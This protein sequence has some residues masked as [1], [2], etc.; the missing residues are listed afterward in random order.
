MRAA[1]AL[2]LLGVVLPAAAVDPDRFMPYGEAPFGPYRAEVCDRFLEHE[3]VVFA[4][5][6]LSGK[7]VEQL[8]R[9]CPGILDIGERVAVEPSGM[10]LYEVDIDNDGNVDQ[11]L[12]LQNLFR[13][14]PPESFFK[15]DLGSC[16]L[17]PVFGAGRPNR[18]FTLAGRTYIESQQRCKGPVKIHGG[19]RYLSCALIYAGDGRELQSYRDELCTFID[20]AWRR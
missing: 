15:L 20:S 17:T 11:V 9:R 7:T 14:L 12:Y 1:A 18:L 19:M 3:R 16:R 4:A 8:L 10:A 6:A 5:P 13:H 2:L